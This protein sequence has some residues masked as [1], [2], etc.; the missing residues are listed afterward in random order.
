MNSSPPRSELAGPLQA[1]SSLALSV[2]LSTNTNTSARRLTVEQTVQVARPDAAKSSLSIAIQ[3]VLFV[4][5]SMII[6]KCSLTEQ[7]QLF[8][9][10]KRN[11]CKRFRGDHHER[12]N[13]KRWRKIWSYAI[14]LARPFTTSSS[15]P[16]SI[17][18][19]GPNGRSLL[20]TN[21]TCSSSRKKGRI[22]GAFNSTVQNIHGE[23]PNVHFLLSEFTI[24]GRDPFLA[25]SSRQPYEVAI[26]WAIN[27]LAGQRHAL[28]R[29][30]LIAIRPSGDSSLSISQRHSAML[31]QTD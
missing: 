22:L 28:F 23:F 8:D 4:A 12:T 5:K 29:K 13:A 25:R 20:P 7:F 9:P 1:C 18:R 27:S 19:Y 16:L 15:R 26:L 10:A 3:Y 31:V 6:D 30:G 24:I 14:L 2:Q 17:T 11:D 21:R